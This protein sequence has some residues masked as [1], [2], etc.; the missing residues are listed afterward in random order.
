MYSNERKSES[1]LLANQNE[2]SLPFHHNFK[3]HYY[4]QMAIIVIAWA[5]PWILNLSTDAIGWIAVVFDCIF[6]SAPSLVLCEVISDWNTD[7][8]SLMGSIP[9]NILGL[10]CSVCWLLEWKLYIP[11]AQLIPSNFFGMFFQ[12]TA[13]ILRVLKSSKAAK[14]QQATPTTNFAVTAEH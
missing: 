5:A 1:V 8:V 10:F 9:M 6:M 4:I 13:L 3:L 14:E 7:N 12:S 11:S 2:L